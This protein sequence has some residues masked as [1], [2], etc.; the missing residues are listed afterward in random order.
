MQLQWV[1]RASKQSSLRTRQKWKEGE[2]LSPSCYFLI[3]IS[4]I[5]LPL[6]HFLPRRGGRGSLS[7]FSFLPHCERFLLAGPYET[8]STAAALQNDFKKRYKRA[9]KGLAAAVANFGCFSDK[10]RC[11]SGAENSPIT[12]CKEIMVIGDILIWKMT[13]SN[14]S[15][16]EYRQLILFVHVI[17]ITTVTTSGPPVKIRTSQSL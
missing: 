2:S 16:I 8:S 12:I 7:F 17:A 3:L 15:S 6:S 13:F 9:V 14:S 5:F 1:W 4:S 11:W 10:Q